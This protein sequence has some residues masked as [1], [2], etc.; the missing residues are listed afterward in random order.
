MKTTTPTHRQRSIHAY[1]VHSHTAKQP[2]SHHTCPHKPTV[3]NNNTF[4]HHT[5]KQPQTYENNNKQT[6]IHAYIQTHKQTSIHV[7]TVHS[8]T[9][10]I[11]AH[12]KQHH[13][14]T[15][16]S[17]THHIHTNT[18]HNHKL[19][20]R[21]KHMKTKTQ[22]HKQKSSHV[23]IEHSHT[24][25]IPT[26]PTARNNAF[27]HASTSTHSHNHKFNQLPHLNHAHAGVLCGEFTQG[28]NK[29]GKN[30]IKT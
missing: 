29:I 19:L 18:Q 30:K 12:I 25:A 9:A 22:T 1:I 27:T 17:L 14:T 3:Q 2:H 24:A 26:K 15:I 13:K 11:H 23:Y 16:H 21:S 4:N 20:R 5:N 6:R 8:H 28:T 10:T 7:Y